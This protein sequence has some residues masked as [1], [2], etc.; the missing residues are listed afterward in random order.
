[1]V[2]ARWALLAVLGLAL[3]VLIGTGAFLAVYYEPS[4]AQALRDGSGVLDDS[5]PPVQVAH[6]VAA[7]GAVGVAVLVA[8]ETA[9]PAASRPRVR[10]VLA[11]LALLAGL[12]ASVWTGSLLPWDQLALRE[13]TTA[14]DTDLRGV[15][16]VFVEDIQFLL[17]DGL[18][19]GTGLYKVLSVVHVAVLPLVVGATWAAL[20]TFARDRSPRPSSPRSR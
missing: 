4:P 12:G 2:T 19:V 1:M 15:T 7:W 16:V 14:P 8:A 6:E 10:A 17:I 3:V 20:T 13:V 9:V 18:E 11:G 5:V